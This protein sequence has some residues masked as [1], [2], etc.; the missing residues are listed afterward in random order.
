MISIKANSNQLWLN[1]VNLRETQEEQAQNKYIKMVKYL[2]GE[3]EQT[4][5]QGNAT[6]WRSSIIAT[7]KPTTD[8]MLQ[9]HKMDILAGHTQCQMTNRPESPMP[10]LVAW[11]WPP[12]AL[13]R[14]E[15]CSRVRSL[16]CESGWGDTGPL[17][18]PTVTRCTILKFSFLPSCSPLTWHH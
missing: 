18:L 1:R 13:T 5:F 10:T 16:C 7:K 8:H 2:H 12:G 15:R 14:E 9:A 6:Y 17:N 4:S 3:E 11:E